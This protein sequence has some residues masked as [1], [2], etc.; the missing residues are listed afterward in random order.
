[1]RLITIALC[2]IL[3]AGCGIPE[4]ISEASR[5]EANAAIARANAERAA[6]EALANARIAEAASQ[7]TIA[8][9]NANA[10]I[11]NTAMAF[12]A[13][14]GILLLAIL[15]LI[16]VLIGYLVYGAIAD[17]RQRRRQQDMLLQM[18]LMDRMP[19]MPVGRQLAAPP[20]WALPAPAND[21]HSLIPYEAT[22]QPIIRQRPRRTQEEIYYR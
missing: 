18:M 19:P 15:A 20:Q 12:D 4:A 3:L 11:A 2:A 21:E 13:L 16:V 14:P 8:T 22:P 6:A 1:M 9:I 10:S 17:N 5:A 7:T